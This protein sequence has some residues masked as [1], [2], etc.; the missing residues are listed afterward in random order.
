MK[1]IAILQSN[2]IPWRGYFN[3]IDSVDEFIVYDDA[4]FTKRDW[5]N[6][7]Q[8]KTPHGVLWLTIPVRTKSRYHQ[9]I[10]ETEIDGRDW[11]DSHIR[12]LEFNYSATPYF[13]D[14][15]GLLEPIYRDKNIFLSELN[16]ALIKAINAYLVIDTKITKSA[17]YS[18]SG[19]NPT[20]KLV[21]LCVHS[22]ASHYV[23]GPA[24]RSYLVTESFLSKNIVTEW[25]DYGFCP[26]YPQAWGLFVDK[27]SI[28]DLLFNCGP[29]SLRYVKREMA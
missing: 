8:I 17:D 12:S 15:I 6:R 3:L 24:A 25:F 2:Y 7:N 1:K 4:Q 18:Y 23:S 14:V 5:R 22:G 26:T 27:L 28:V 19:D 13:N 29:Q 21:D 10:R 20:D 9:T 11:V 16:I